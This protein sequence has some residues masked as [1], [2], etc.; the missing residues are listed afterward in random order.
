MFQMNFMW[1]HPSNQIRNSEICYIT[2]VKWIMHEEF[3]NCNASAFFSNSSAHDAC[4]Q[5]D[6]YR[7]SFPVPSRLAEERV[8]HHMNKMIT[9]F[10]CSFHLLRKAETPPHNHWALNYSQLRCWM[11]ESDVFFTADSLLFSFFCALRRPLNMEE[12]VED[13]MG[14]TTLHELVF[15]ER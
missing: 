8:F 7:Q 6:I 10:S 11:A 15:A 12:K 3:L 9:Q 1:K 13:V 5:F 2:G 14:I 4:H